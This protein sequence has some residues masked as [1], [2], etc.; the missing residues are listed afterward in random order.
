MHL[1]RRL[2]V[3]SFRVVIA[4]AILACGAFVFNKWSS[5]PANSPPSAGNS[6]GGVE[7]DP[8]DLPD[9][10]LVQ[11]TS[12]VSSTSYYLKS[13]NSLFGLGNEL[14]TWDR[15]HS[16]KQDHL[17][18]LDFGYPKVQG[19]QYGVQL[20]DDPY[21]RF[22]DTTTVIN[23]V[24]NFGVDY[25]NAVH[26]WDSQSHL[27]ID[28]G[29]NNCCWYDPY[30]LFSGH[31]AAWANTVNTIQTQIAANL[32]SSQVDVRAGMDI[33]QA[34]PVNGQGGGGGDPYATYL[35][36][37][38]YRDHS[39]CNPTP[40]MD[41][42]T[43]GCFYNFGTWQSW[44]ITEACHT[45]SPQPPCSDPHDACYQWNS[46]DMWYMSWGVPKNGYRFARPVPEIYHGYAS[47]LPWGTDANYWKELSRYSNDQQ[48]TGPMFFVGT[49][50]ERLSC[51]DDCGDG[52]NYPW[53]GFQLLSRALAS[54][55]TTRQA[56]R[57]TTAITHMDY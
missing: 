28:V 26:N 46:C 48:Y 1:N 31:G 40:G 10:G 2:I 17:V 20:V 6:P 53:E 15:N 52:N 54:N 9:T 32:A 35:W 39:S 34:K 57:W 13:S 11:L 36:L 38:A 25:Y 21:K 29:V 41:N 47:M 22:M 42:T 5:Q 33:E 37:N 45:T 30:T 18:I 49:L 51:N 23:L 16:G 44:S 12:P 8:I 43:E 3:I 7:D 56:M 14:G 19:G 24:V 55:T 4:L 50:T 27:R